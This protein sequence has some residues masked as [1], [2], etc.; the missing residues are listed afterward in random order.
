M[1]QRCCLN[2]VCMDAVYMKSDF[3][4]QPRYASAQCG[5][6]RSYSHKQRNKNTDTNIHILIF[7]FA[8]RNKIGN[9]HRGSSRRWFSLTGRTLPHHHYTCR[10]QRRSTVTI[11]HATDTTRVEWPRSM[12]LDS[13]KLHA[14]QA[15]NCPL[16][17]IISSSKSIGPGIRIP[18]IYVCHSADDRHKHK[19]VRAHKWV[20]V[21]QVTL[22][23]TGPC[24]ERVL[25]DM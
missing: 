1:L 5:H 23:R 17:F 8:T 9:L 16:P 3:W 14:L 7:V 15:C 25:A 10:M 4:K 20:W 12:S 2:V 22:S 6:D 11:D 18:Y 21:S 24:H 19:S 13:F